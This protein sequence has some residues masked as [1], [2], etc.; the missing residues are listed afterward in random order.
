MVS[1]RNG[2]EMTVGRDGCEVYEET[3]RKVQTALSKRRV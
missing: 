1:R 3:G 2:G